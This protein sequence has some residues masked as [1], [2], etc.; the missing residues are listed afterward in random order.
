MGVDGNGGRKAVRQGSIV[1]KISDIKQTHLT[2]PILM[3]TNI[4]NSHGDY[5][6]LVY[7]VQISIHI[8]NSSCPVYKNPTILC[9]DKKYNW[10]LKI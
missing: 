3:V 5:Q 8:F 2:T 9:F 6:Q 4:T 7:D 1:T 10:T